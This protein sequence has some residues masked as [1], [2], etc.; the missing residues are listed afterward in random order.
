[1]TRLFIF[2]PA[3]IRQQMRRV[4]YWGIGMAAS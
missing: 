2:D 1:M 4:D 3:Y